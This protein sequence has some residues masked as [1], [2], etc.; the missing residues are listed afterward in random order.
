MAQWF[1][2]AT[3]IHHSSPGSPALR[4]A[5]HVNLTSEKICEKASISHNT[6]M[7]HGAGI[8]I[9]TFARKKS[10]SFIG[11]YTSTMEHMG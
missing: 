11:I 2:P 6:H 5:H 3:N 4:V 10:P 7:I 1:S 9:P 8:W